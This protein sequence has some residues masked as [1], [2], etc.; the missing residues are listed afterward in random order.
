VRIERRRGWIWFAPEAGRTAARRLAPGGRVRLGGRDFVASATAATVIVAPL[1]AAGRRALAARGCPTPEMLGRPA[2]S[3]A[4][5]E[6]LPAVFDA[7]GGLV[8]CPGLDGAGE[9]GEAGEAGLLVAPFA[10]A[11]GKR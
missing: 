2:P 5:L 6:G 10:P 4:L 7:A 8:G 1:G 9:A 11:G 3:A